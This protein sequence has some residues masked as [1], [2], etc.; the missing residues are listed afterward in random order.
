MVLKLIIKDDVWIIRYTNKKSALRISVNSYGCQSWLKDGLLHRENG[1][2]AF[3]SLT[4]WRYH[5]N[6]ALH[7]EDGPAV[8]FDGDKTW[9]VDNIE[10]YNT[11]E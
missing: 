5:F 2:A 9:Y 8:N 1:P 6:G 3:T 7:R 11:W 10:L 4:R